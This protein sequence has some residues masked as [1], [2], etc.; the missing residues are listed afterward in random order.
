[1]ECRRW[2]WQALRKMKLGAAQLERLKRAREQ[3]PLLVAQAHAREVQRALGVLPGEA[4][5]YSRHAK[6]IVQPAASGHHGLRKVVAILAQA[7]DL[8]RVKG[9]D[10]SVAFLHQAYKAAQAACYHP[11]KQWTYGWPLLGLEDP[12]GTQQPG[13]T[14]SEHAALAAFHR[15]RELLHRQMEAPGSAA[16]ASADV[17]GR[18]GVRSLAGAADTAAATKPK[19]GD[20]KLRAEIDK[21]KKDLAAAKKKGKGKGRGADAPD[22]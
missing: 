4:W 20:D 1:M 15:D 6:D 2:S 7:L 12:D 8:H 16:S 19:S 3:Q 17:P 14:P 11:Q 9:A 13:F 5:S 10:H 22:L 18:G 21:L